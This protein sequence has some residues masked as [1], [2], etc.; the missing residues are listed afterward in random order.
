MLL[1]KTIF[2]GNGGGV[3]GFKVNKFIYLNKLVYK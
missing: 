1:D 3:I 2:V